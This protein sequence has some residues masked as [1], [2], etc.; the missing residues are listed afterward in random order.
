[1][2]KLY[3]SHYEISNE[4]ILVALCGPAVHWNCWKFT[5]L[6]SFNENCQVFGVSQKPDLSC[7]KG[8]DLNI[9][10]SL[11]YK[12]MK[13]VVQWKKKCCILQDEKS[14]YPTT[15]PFCLFFRVSQH[16]LE[17]PYWQRL[18][19]H[20]GADGQI[21]WNILGERKTWDHI[22]DRYA[23]WHFP[24]PIFILPFH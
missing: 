21:R 3:I 10:N 6:A 18:L 17:G 13:S 23:E 5:T 9:R 24:M 11:C 1:M 15:Y 14:E 7:S 2:I 12:L 20:K 22:S 4:N 16:F 8:E 19:Q